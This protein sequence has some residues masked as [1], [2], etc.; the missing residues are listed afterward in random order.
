ML[1]PY[2]TVAVTN[3]EVWYLQFGTAS[4]SP[5]CHTILYQ[6]S[7][8]HLGTVWYSKFGTSLDRKNFVDT[9]VCCHIAYRDRGCLTLPLSGFVCLENSN[10]YSIATTI[11]KLQYYLTTWKVNAILLDNDGQCLFHPET[12]PLCQN[13]PPHKYSQETWRLF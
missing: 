3:D 10:F 1:P 2:H 5:P 11:V 8:G 4:L 9:C 12:R 13:I 6:Y 7:L